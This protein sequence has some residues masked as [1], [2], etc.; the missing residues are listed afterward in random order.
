MYHSNYVN[1][2]KKK[3]KE[4][5]GNINIPNHFDK[6]PCVLVRKKKGDEMCLTC[7]T[8]PIDLTKFPERQQC[9]HCNEAN[10]GICRKTFQKQTFPKQVTK[11]KTMSINRIIKIYKHLHYNHAYPLVPCTIKQ[12]QHCHKVIISCTLYN[13][14]NVQTYNVT[15]TAL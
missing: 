11:N 6:M 1:I 4:G 14:N 10:L 15:Y 3:K 2:T 13:V 5:K 7:S 8:Y 9:Q 12:I